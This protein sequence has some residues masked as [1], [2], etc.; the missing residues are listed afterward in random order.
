ML[1]RLGLSLT[2]L[3]VGTGA[4]AQ[5]T[6]PRVNEAKTACAAGDVQQ[7]VRLLAELYTAT[8][9]PI[10]IFNQGR[11]Y[12]QNNQLPLAEARFKEFL[13]KNVNGPA[14]DSR[15]AQNYINEI[16]AEIHKNDAKSPATGGD[17]AGIAKSGEETHDYSKGRG[18]RYAGIGC[19]ILGAAALASGI[20]FSLLTSTANQDVENKTRNDTVPSS[21]VHGSLQN[22]PIYETLQW[23]G[24]GVGAASVIT[25]AVLYYMGRKATEPAPA[26]APQ[27]EATV[28][29]APLL[30]TGGAGAVMHL[31]F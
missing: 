18:L 2:V 1:S 15:D 4:F 26:A 16:E 24:Y 14:E 28:A 8:N 23:V 19:G 17:T 31:S 11:C 20:V 13:R 12:H 21:A 5:G 29:V 10:W 9:D 7:A 6:D 25:G 30:L 22:G 27:P 3:L